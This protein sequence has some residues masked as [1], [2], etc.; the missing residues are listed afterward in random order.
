MFDRE[1]NET[2]EFGSLATILRWLRFNPTEDD[3]KNFKRRFDPLQKNEISLM[4]VY[5]IVDE[6]LVSPDTFEQLGEALRLFDNDNDGKIT[7]PEFRWFMSKLGDVFDEKEVDE[8][9]KE[10]DKENTGFVEITTFCRTAFNIKEEKPK[11]EK[12][13]K[14]GADAPKKKK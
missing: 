8:L 2:C 9:L 3:I 12:D 4:S 6:F 7:V 10:V 11:G 1:K 14:K 5:A 13:A